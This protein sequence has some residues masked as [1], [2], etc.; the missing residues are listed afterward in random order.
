MD[1]ELKNNLR[2]RATW[3]RGLYMLLFIVIFHV[4]EVVVGAVVLL[5]FLFT[6]F[7]GATNARLLR[8]GQSLSQYVY[9]ILRFLSFNS[10][11]M[12]F[13]FSEWPTTDETTDA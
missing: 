8:F 9:Q 4:A 6:L 5:Q 11:E 13:P 10:E 2:K 12:P 1:S 7:S 3:L